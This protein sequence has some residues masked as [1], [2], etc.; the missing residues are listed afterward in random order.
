[1]A[2]QV[3][4]KLVDDIDGK[5]I[6]QGGETVRFAVDGVSYEI[7]L[8]DR[9]AKKLRESLAPY[10][11]HARR[12]RGS[13]IGSSASKAKTDKTHVAAIRQWA[14]DNGYTV[15]DRGRISQDIQKAY[16]KAR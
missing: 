2:Q 12:V 4:T 1:M 3:I 14:R 16:A 9:N 7:D 6:T 5:E 8:N 10:M 13:R 15:S 11:D